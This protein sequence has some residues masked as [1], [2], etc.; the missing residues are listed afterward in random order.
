MNADQM[1]VLPPSVK[2]FDDYEDGLA[3]KKQ[4]G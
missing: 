3:Q 2:L 4:L 1:R